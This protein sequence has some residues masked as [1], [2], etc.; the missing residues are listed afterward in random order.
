[1]SNQQ[2]KTHI[3]S[4]CDEVRQYKTFE[5]LKLQMFGTV[6]QKVPETVNGQS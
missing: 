6:T 3:Y 5:N 1:M 2:S 4:V